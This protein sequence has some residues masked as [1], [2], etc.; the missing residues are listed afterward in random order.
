MQRNH[1]KSIMATS[2]IKQTSDGRWTLENRG[3]GRKPKV[4]RYNTKH[5]QKK[6]HNDHVDDFKLKVK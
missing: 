2:S 3:R 5:S 6:F 4:L 1:Y